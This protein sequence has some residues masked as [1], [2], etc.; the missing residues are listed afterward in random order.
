VP[1]NINQVRLGIVN[2]LSLELGK[3]VIALPTSDG[4]VLNFLVPEPDVHLRTAVQALEGLS[5]AGARAEVPFGL[6]IGLNSH[7]DTLIIDINNE[8]NVVGSGINIAERV[9]DLG[10]HGQIL[11]HD[12]V[13]L[14][15]EKYPQYAPKLMPRGEY[16]AKNGEKIQITQYVDPSC[17]YLCNDPVQLPSL[18]EDTPVNLDKILQ[19]SI[20]NNLLSVTLDHRGRDHLDGIR[21]YIEE[22]LDGAGGA[23]AG[24]LQRLRV[25]VPW[26]ASEMLA[27]AF[28][29]GHIG[30]GDQIVL[31]LRR[32]S[33][34]ILVELEQPDIPDLQVAAILQDER[35]QDSFMQLVHR[36]GLRWRQRRIGDR[37]E[38]GLEIPNNLILK[39]MIALT[40]DSNAAAAGDLPMPVGAFLHGVTDKCVHGG[41]LLIRLLP[42]ALDNRSAEGTR[43]LL[44]G[45][46]T[47]IS[48]IRA[49]II[50]LSLVNYIPSVGLRTLL[51]TSMMAKSNDCAF[52][53][54]NV[55]PNV[56]EIFNLARFNA[57]LELYENSE[58]AFRALAVG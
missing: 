6:R 9:M 21:E 23:M 16:T 34:G 56:R 42:D 1:A 33:S 53:A 55:N 14:D 32:T 31:R 48:H 58:S 46:I 7:V 35:H 57:V 26:V 5:E 29:Y 25:S 37:L 13:K 39:P 47:S 45:L 54:T 43:Q 44:L 41:A 17:S 50:D 19:H 2:K 38:L 20:E 22:F 27:N 49:L 12:R 24:E 3:E 36:R 4:A 10:R 52:V 11:M 51:V 30:R 18:A 15:L 8:I 40:F 28:A